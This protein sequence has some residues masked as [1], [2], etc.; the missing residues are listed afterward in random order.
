MTKLPDGTY[1]YK[2]IF[3]TIGKTISNEGFLHLW[4]GFPTFY[5]RIAPHV[6]LTWLFMGVL[7]TSVFPLQKK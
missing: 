3:H 4:V 6:L 2:N 7:E 1:P 5:A